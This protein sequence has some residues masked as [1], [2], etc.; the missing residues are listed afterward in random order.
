[1]EL[2]LAKDSVY[3]NLITFLLLNAGAGCSLFLRWL[4]ALPGVDL[5]VGC[6]EDDHV[7]HEDDDTG[8]EHGHN[9]GQDDV[10]LAVL[11]S[12]VI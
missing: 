12:I 2:Y 5:S 4:I 10:K 6:G 7:A 9:D 3:S 8:T 11:L 1:M